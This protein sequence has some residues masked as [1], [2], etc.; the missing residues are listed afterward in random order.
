MGIAAVRP[1][2]V[3]D[4]T[5][6][7]STPRLACSD[8]KTEALPNTGSALLNLLTRT[9]S[10]PQLEAHAHLGLFL[11]NVWRLWLGRMFQ[12]SWYLDY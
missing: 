7:P 5:A 12:S 10:V 6:A 8:G 4:A 1:L 2:I 3:S 9:I 11:K